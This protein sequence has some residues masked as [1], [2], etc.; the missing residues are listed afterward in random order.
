MS[1]IN[2][3]SVKQS[4]PVSV[5]LRIE[6]DGIVIELLHALRIR[7][8]RGYGLLVRLLNMVATFS[9]PTDRRLWVTNPKCW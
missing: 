3:E 9:G 8:A 1:G 5:V 4:E 2:S 6:I 7:A